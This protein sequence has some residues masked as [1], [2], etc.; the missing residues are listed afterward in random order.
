MEFDSFFL[1]KLEITQVVLEYRCCFFVVFCFFKLEITQ[2][3][4]ESC[5]FFF[6]QIRNHAILESHS[7]FSLLFSNKKSHA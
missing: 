7:F 5:S 4:F 1:F 3:V 2:V 6:F